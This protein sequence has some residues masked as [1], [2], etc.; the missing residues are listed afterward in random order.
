MLSLVNTLEEE[1]LEF[2]CKNPTNRYTVTEVSNKLDYSKPS[3]SGKFTELENKEILEITKK[4]NTKLASFKREENKQLKQLINLNRLQNTNII[5][6]I[7]EDHQYPQA[8]ILFGSFAKGEDTE[9]SDIDIAVISTQNSKEDYGNIMERKI[10]ITKF[11]PSQIP[12]NM[13][14]TLANGITLYGYLQLTKK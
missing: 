8:V 5:Q 7:V 13:L 1:V 2:F 10:S 3:I 11:E 14:E 6:K 9:K 4:R 12:E